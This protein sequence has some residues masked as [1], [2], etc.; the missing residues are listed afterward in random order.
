MT[1]EWV[2]TQPNI[3][4]GKNPN[5]GIIKE[6]AMDDFLNEFN[7]NVPFQKHLQ[8]SRD[9]FD[10]LDEISEHLQNLE[11][12]A[13]EPEDFYKRSDGTLDRE[14]L[15]I[16]KT[17]LRT[18]RDGIVEALNSATSQAQSDPNDPD[19]SLQEQGFALRDQWR[20]DN[21][22][23]GEDWKSSEIY[24][25]GNKPL[26]DAE[27]ARIAGTPETNGLSDDE[28]LRL[29]A[30]RVKQKKIL[31]IVDKS[32]ATFAPETEIAIKEMLDKAAWLH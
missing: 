1:G 17:K 27:A 7:Y 16:S 31:N 30:T 3:V 24:N 6:V 13:V 11:R 28:V 12:G 10:G 14:K 25:N 22:E 15:E 32:K 9:Y 19:Q 2:S 5:F 20:D 26:V 23:P 8:S 18:A 21:F 29:A 4:E